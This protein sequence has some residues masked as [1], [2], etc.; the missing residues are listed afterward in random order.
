MHYHLVT[1]VEKDTHGAARL[2][3][4]GVSLPGMPGIQIGHT[5][6]FAWSIT[7][8]SHDASDLFAEK[9]EPCANQSSAQLCYLYK[10]D[11]RPLQYRREVI[12]IRGHEDFVED[13]IS[14]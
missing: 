13:V 11:H 4:T 9:L 14:V 1:K 2:N 6:Q 3:V 10:G 5:E 12:H 7:T 8:S